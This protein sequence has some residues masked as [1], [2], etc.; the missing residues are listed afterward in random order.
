MMVGAVRSGAGSTPYEAAV[1]PARSLNRTLAASAPDSPNSSVDFFES[2][3]ATLSKATGF[4]DRVNELVQELK[5]Q[6]DRALTSNAKASDVADL[7]KVPAKP[8][9][10]DHDS[11]DQIS[12]IGPAL[13]TLL[14][15][16]ANGSLN[17]L[18]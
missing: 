5:L 6:N 18:A 15:L 3:S 17:E 8:E 11:D 9:K 16:P 14:A 12:R 2:L 4:Q 7:E 13:L 1:D 10:S